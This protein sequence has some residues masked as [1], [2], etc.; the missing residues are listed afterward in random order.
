MEQR[1]C[2]MKKVCEDIQSTNPWLRDTDPA[3][4]GQLQCLRYRRWPVGRGRLPDSKSDW[5]RVLFASVRIPSVTEDF[6]S[7]CI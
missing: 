3:L 1:H 7:V 6:C 5:C 2:G 4:Q